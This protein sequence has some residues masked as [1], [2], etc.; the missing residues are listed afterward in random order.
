[1][2]SIVAGLALA[3]LASGARAS[4]LDTLFHNGHTYQL[5]GTGHATNWTA[6]RTLAG[7]LTFGGTTG[8]LARIDTLAEN[9]AIFARML[10]V[11]N[12]LTQT[13]GDG[14][15]VEYVWIGASDLAAEGTWL[16]S[17]DNAQFWQGNAGGTA[18]GGLYN[19]WG[20]PAGTRF[21][22]D[23]FNASQDAAGIALRGWPAGMG[24]LGLAGQWNDVNV[25]NNLPYVVE[26]DALP[27]PATLLLLG[28]A[29]LAL[30]PRLRRREGSESPD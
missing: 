4:L 7:G 10:A 22:P 20:N 27:E 2:R 3:A 12:Q 5:Y 29:L 13:A 24:I 21:E 16:W 26:F 9:S 30:G 6:A 28:P 8:Y 19:N 17:V 18:V 14:G 1:M 11:S 25:V 23:D 15:G